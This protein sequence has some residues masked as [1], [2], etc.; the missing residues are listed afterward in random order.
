MSINSIK[1]LD[2]EEALHVAALA[3]ARKAARPSPS[4]KRF[5][6]G[7]DKPRTPEHHALTDCLAGLDDDSH[8]ELAAVALLGHRTAAKAH[9]YAQFLK[10][11]KKEHRTPCSEIADVLTYISLGDHIRNGLTKLGV[12]S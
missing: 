4:I 7:M 11:A 8:A 3:D 9:H 12:L 6:A 1:Y 5:G 2:V 10:A